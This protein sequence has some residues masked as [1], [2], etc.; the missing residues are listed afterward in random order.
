M[1]FKRTD[2]D[3]R[4]NGRLRLVVFLLLAMPWLQ[5]GC[6][7]VLFPENEPITQ[8]DLYDRLRNRY[9]PME[10]PDPFGTPRP[11]LRARLTPP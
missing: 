4:N 7:K 10:E 2:N 9:V 8:F 11:A 1:S 6:Q 5:C 3:G